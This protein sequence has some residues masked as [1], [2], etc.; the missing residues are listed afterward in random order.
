MVVESIYNHY[1]FENNYVL[2]YNHLTNVI[3]RV[4]DSEMFRGILDDIKSGKEPGESPLFTQLIKDNF[5]VD[6]NTDE[7]ALGEL[8]YQDGIYDTTLNVTILASEQCNFRCGYCYEDFKRG[9]ITPEVI[10]S[11]YKFMK[12][13]IHKYNKVNVSWFGG[14]PLLAAGEIER[15]SDQLIDLCNKNGKAYLADMTTNGYL[16]TADMMR[17]MLKCRVLNYQITLDGMGEAH[18]TTRSLAGGGPTFETIIGNLRAIR[19]TVTSRMLKITLRSNISKIQLATIDRY[20]QFIHDEFGND[21]RFECYFRPAGNWGGERV[22]GMKDELVSSFDELYSPLLRNISKLNVNAYIPLLKIAVC[23][24][25]NRN[26]FV[27]GSDGTIYKCTMLFNEDFNK[28]GQMTADGRM[29]LDQSKFA[30]WTATAAEPA[31]TC[32]SCNVWSLCHNRSCPARVFSTNKKNGANCGYE[33]K[34]MDYVL[35][36]LDGAGSKNITTYGTGEVN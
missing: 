24:A 32:R 27:L 33:R 30:R 10:D 19:D 14:E 21:P 5:F 12:K 20:I 4:M 36:F 28:L 35:K 1:F 8:A 17:R 26:S 13:N 22:N 31:E 7:R 23:N 2:I 34:S 25:A 6:K 29:E 18:N 9:N 16:L 3:G 11:F 15:I